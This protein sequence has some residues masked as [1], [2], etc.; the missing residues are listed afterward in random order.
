MKEKM[1]CIMK[2]LALEMDEQPKKLFHATKPSNTSSI[3]ENGLRPHEVYGE[4]YFC[5]KEKE[6]LKFIKKPCVIFE[7][8]PSKL[9]MKEM[10]LSREAKQWQAYQYYLNV[11][12]EAIKGWK[13]HI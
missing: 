3:L 8:D 10:Y 12:K 2:N 5:D 7:I 4:V 11:P 1:N 13:T 6:C 9:D